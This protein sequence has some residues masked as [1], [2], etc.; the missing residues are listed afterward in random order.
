MAPSLFR[1]FY[2][3]F[4]RC[5]W[6]AETDVVFNGIVEQIDLLK[7]HRDIAKQTITGHILH[8]FTVYCDLAAVHIIEAG[9]QVA[10][11]GLAAAGWPYNG[12][13]AALGDGK[14]DIPQNRNFFIV[15]ECHITESNVCV[16]Q[17]NI[18]PIFVYNVGV[19]N[20]V[21][22]IQRSINNLQYMG[23]VVH[24]FHTSKD[25]KGEH[26]QHEHGRKFHIAVIGQ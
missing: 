24:G 10:N 13:S 3:F 12:R 7:D 16:L 11:R 9:N 19:L 23:G 20:A 14:A 6:I 26:I 8:I 2:N 5:T 21:Q 22:F 4:L 1:S 25:H 18:F 15:G 17:R